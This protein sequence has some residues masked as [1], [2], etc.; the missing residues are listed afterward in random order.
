M[1][2][3]HPLDT[4]NNPLNNLHDSLMDAAWLQIVDAIGGVITLTPER[5]AR[6]LQG[7]DDALRR[8]E[9]EQAG[10]PFVPREP[11]WWPDETGRFLYRPDKIIVTVD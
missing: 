11:Q 4:L 3:R 2:R 1:E 8:D 10:E 6:I 7:I 5:A 9:A